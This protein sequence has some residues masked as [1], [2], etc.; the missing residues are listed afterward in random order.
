MSAPPT[1]QPPP[2][3]SPAATQLAGV[4]VVDLTRILSGPFC[5]MLLADLGADVIKIEPPEGDPV[6]GQ[7][8]GRD[9]MSWY[10]AAFNRNKRS[11]RLD[12]RSAAGLAALKDLIRTADVV[13][14][15]FRP[16]VM[17]RMGL[18]WDTLQA[19]SPGL[20][21]TSINGFGDDGPYA[22][23]PA[24]DFIAQAMSG[25]MSMN[26]TPETGPLRSAL[27][28]SDLVAG[29]YAALGT[30]A[31]LYRRRAT[32]R[33]ERVCAALVDSLLSY[34]SFA[35][36]NY[37]ASGRLPVP[38]GNDHP[39]V[40]PYGLFSAADGEIAIAPSND[41]VY[42]RLLNALGLQRLN[43]DPRF[44]SNALRMQHRAEINAEIDAALRPQPREHWIRVLNRAGV[45]CGTVLTL[46][47]VYA[48]PQVQSQQMVI[49]VEHPG[50]GTVRMNGFPIK[51]R[52]A[53]CQV[54]YPAP[55][56]GQHTEE[57]L[58]E[59]GYDAARIAALKPAD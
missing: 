30:V 45:P 29:N 44:A 51:F 17:G 58:G 23:R 50:H 21:Q 34:G 5:T 27:P 55:D 16:D 25:F 40:A 59:L 36:S 56:P 57:V 31:A 10:F 37:L 46:D 33:G 38:S 2:A 24:F 14:E 26:G 42:Q 41:G 8:D 28:I 48:D 3:P 6:R 39:I 7:G 20:I 54:R 1:P 13:V 53:P 9:G 19:L 47:Q 15:N 11:V 49:D 22:D 43:D 4:R 52:D 12:L 18:D 32:G 35:S